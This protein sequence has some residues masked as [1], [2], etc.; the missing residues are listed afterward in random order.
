MTT[1]T[2][3]ENSLLR[4]ARVF[5]SDDDYMNLHWPKLESAIL[6]IL[7][8]S[9]GQFIPISYEEMYSTVYKCV[10]QQ[11]ADRMYSNLIELVAT[12]LR[13][14]SIELQETPKEAYLEKFHFVMEQFFQA[15][16][17]IVAIFSYMNRFYVTTK[18]QTD[19]KTELGKLFTSLV[20]DNDFLFTVIEEVS[21]KPFGADPQVMM[22]IVK[23]LY[24]LKPE[25]SS[26]NPVLFAR[27]IPNL[28]PP[29]QCEQLP[30]LIQEDRM[31]QEDLVTSQ[32]FSRD[33]TGKKRRG[34]DFHGR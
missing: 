26:R 16:S 11:Y 9:P 33:D 23:G 10:C 3:S 21:S 28:L 12:Y 19:L 7:R 13:G 17:G 2:M 18:L 6:L 30:S 34:D 20:A 5:L 14:V 8:Q 25:F 24:S 22:S 27:F 4:Q 1:N 31:L 15:V 29:T 32:G